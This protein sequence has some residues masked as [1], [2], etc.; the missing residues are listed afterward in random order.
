MQVGVSRHVERSAVVF[1]R[2]VRVAIVGAGPAGIFLADSLL[3][4]DKAQF[5]ID[6]IE[7]LPAPYGLV[8][9]GVAP[10]HYKMKTVIN[11]FHKTLDDAR[12]RF[13]GNVT[14]GKNLSVVD[15]RRHYDAV[16]YTVGASADRRLDVPGEDLPGNLSATEFVAWYNGHPDHATRNLGLDAEAV[17]VVGV[18]NVAVDVTRILAKHVDELRHTDIPE[19]VLDVLAQSRVKDIYVLG[20]R[21][22]AQAKFTTKELRELG[23][24]PNADVIVRNDEIELDERSAQTVAASA[25][26]QRNM[27]ALRGFAARVPEGRPRRIHLR[28]LCSPAM[29]TGAQSVEGL[30]LEKNALDERENAVGTGIFETLGVQLVLRSVGYRG[31]PLDGLPFDTKRHVIPNGHGRILGDDGVP[32]M[33]QYVAGWI[34]RGPSGVIGTNKPDAAE[35]AGALIED[36]DGLEPAP[37]WEPAS[38]DALLRARGIPVVLWKHWLE[39]DA[40]EIA[41]GTAGGRP[42]V[43]LTAFDQF[44]PQDASLTARP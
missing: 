21:G 12:V 31:V 32:L 11:T 16:V 36:L 15:L 10:D 42:R 6:V 43:K 8:R 1:D 44:I 22:P 30:R 39:I 27:E 4:S 2:P 28:F 9:Y 40:Q 7:R 26:L 33:G 25:V 34:K 17:A 3:K 38:I 19:P 18:G 14:F 29:I 24:L 20:R 13:I 5:S 41:L 37:E 23:E 35:T